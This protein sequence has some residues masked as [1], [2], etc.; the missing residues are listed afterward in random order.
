MLLSNVIPQ[1]DEIPALHLGMP[2]SP[3][4]QLRDWH[5]WIRAVPF[6]RADVRYFNSL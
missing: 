6:D 1:G 2:V 4:L 5:P 3:L